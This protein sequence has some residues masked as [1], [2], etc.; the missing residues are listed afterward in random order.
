MINANDI[1]KYLLEINEYLKKED[2]NGEIVLAGGAVMALVYRARN[3]T[4]DIDALFKP[5]TEIRGII[6][7]IAKKHNLQKDWLN[8]GVKG[9]ITDKMK[10]DIY[11]EYSNLTIYTINAE[12]L[13]A[14]KLTSARFDSK[15]QSD[16]L[17]LMNYLKIKN[18]NQL[19][20]IVDK[21]IPENRHT[22][23]SHY[24]IQDTYDKYLGGSKRKK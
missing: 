11:A 1:E 24:F 15:D 19:Y 20:K 22:I 10:Q 23:N 8:D 13:L 18:I 7:K 5:S 3:S 2:R 9:F 12:S 17:F 14:M 6:T 16:A 4:Q 21:Y